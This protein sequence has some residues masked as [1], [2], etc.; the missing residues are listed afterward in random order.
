MLQPASMQGACFNVVDNDKFQRG[1][2]L[3]KVHALIKTHA[4]TRRD[5]SRRSMA[6]GLQQV[7]ILF[8]DFLKLSWRCKQ[9]ERDVAPGFTLRFMI[10]GD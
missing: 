2:A 4:L 7:S 3:V 1:L 6:T 10:L 9:L 5:C 8:T